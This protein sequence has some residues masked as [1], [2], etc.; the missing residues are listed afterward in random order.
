[1]NTKKI[2]RRQFLIDPAFQYRFVKKLVSMTLL[3]VMTASAGILF[4][5]SLME[6]EIL[7][8]DPFSTF[9]SVTLATMPSVAWMLSHL[10]PYFLL[11]LGLV[12]VIS[13][14][15]GVIESFRIAGPGFRM[16]QMLKSIARGD[17]TATKVSLRK[18]DELESLYSEIVDVHLAWKANIEHLQAICDS[19]D[20]P[21]VKVRQLRE[22]VFSFKL[23]EETRS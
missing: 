10:W 3:V 21:D 5:L 14:L 4:V 20:K 13:L 23:K 17:F 1:M 18:G 6:K 2:K 7:Q 9:H 8:P 15:F 22:K 19:D 12:A 16:R 11:A